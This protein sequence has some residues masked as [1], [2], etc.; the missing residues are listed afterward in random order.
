MSKIATVTEPTMADVLAALTAFKSD[1]DEKISRLA[2]AQA[3]MLESEPEP[4]PEESTDL[5]S[6]KAWAKSKG[7]ETRGKWTEERISKVTAMKDATNGKPAQSKLAP[8]V[9]QV[10]SS[11]RFALQV[12]ESNGSPRGQR[13]TR[14]QAPG[15]LANHPYLATML[16]LESADWLALASHGAGEKKDKV[17]GRIIRK[18][19]ANPTG[20]T[21]NWRFIAKTM[22][23][24]AMVGN[25]VREATPNIRF[26]ACNLVQ[27]LVETGKLA[28]V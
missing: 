4:Q 15:A 10:P 21:S 3:A 26:E 25:E 1:V 5:A 24:T 23:G 11:G 13:P 17:T 7:I 12:A 20:M 27:H 8:S 19:L 28:K 22:S 6:L 2:K 18:G 16:A 9:A 14:E